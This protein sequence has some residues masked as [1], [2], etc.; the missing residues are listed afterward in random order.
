MEIIRAYISLRLNVR[1]YNKQRS[2]KVKAQDW[3][4]YFQPNHLVFAFRVLLFCVMEACIGDSIDEHD[5]RIGHGR[6]P[7]RDTRRSSSVSTHRAPNMKQSVLPLP[8]KP[9]FTIVYATRARM[10]ADV[11][12]R[13]HD[14]DSALN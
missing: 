13:H 9:C 1:S 4:D 5:C 8:K 12:V 14:K 3:L 7:L 6:T 10:Q 2:S 11:S